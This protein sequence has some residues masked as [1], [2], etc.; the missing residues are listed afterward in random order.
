MA[1]FYTHPEFLASRRTPQ[2]AFVLIA[3]AWFQ[4]GRAVWTSLN[5]PL[6]ASRSYKSHTGETSVINPL[7]SAAFIGWDI[8]VARALIF[9]LFLFIEISYELIV[10]IELT[11]MCSRVR[12]VLCMIEVYLIIIASRHFWSNSK[13]HKFWILQNDETF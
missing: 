11:K 12:H 8:L 10:I 2:I 5:L 4:P 7:L 6:S 1:N 13:V 9:F 3:T